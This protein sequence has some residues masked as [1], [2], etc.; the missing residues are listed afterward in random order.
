MHVLVG[1]GG[2]A[3]TEVGMGWER[4]RILSHAECGLP[5]QGTWS[6]SGHR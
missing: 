4:R 6:W 1:F 3:G 2:L 5:W